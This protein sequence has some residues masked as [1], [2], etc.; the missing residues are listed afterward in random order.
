MNT[1]FY[2]CGGAARNRR[3]RLQKAKGPELVGAF[4]SSEGEREN[5]VP[6]ATEVEA[7][8]QLAADRLH[9]LFRVLEADNSCSR[10]DRERSPCRNAERRVF[11]A[12]GR[13]A[14]FGLPVQTRKE[15]EAVLVT[16]ADEPALVLLRVQR[17]PGR[18]VIQKVGEGNALEA[19]FGVTA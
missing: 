11:G 14:I 3:A 12:V 4:R 6:A 16:G 9:V 19:R 1:E 15:V 7:V 8:D 17:H 10:D 5:S 18:A 13:V 2:T